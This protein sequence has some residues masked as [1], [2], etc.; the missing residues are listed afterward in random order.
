VLKILIYLPTILILAAFF[1]HPVYG[2]QNG[3]LE[4]S[5]AFSE[6]VLENPNEEKKLEISFT[7]HS[8]R[9]TNLEIFPIDFKQTGL[10]GDLNFVQ[11]PG[12]YSYSLSSFLSLESNFLELKGGEERI[13]NVSIKNRE[14][15]SPG[16]H[17]AAVVAKVVD[18]KEDPA[19]AAIAPSISSLILLRKSGGERFSLS[20]VS[21]DYPS[22]TIALAYPKVLTLLFQNEGNIHLIPYG[23]VEIKDMFN[24]LLHEGTINSASHIILPESKRYIKADLIKLRKSFPISINT[25][26]VHGQDSLKKAN[27]TFRETYLY[28]HPAVIVVF[29]LIPILTIIII[30]YNKKMSKK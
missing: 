10:F 18:I 12:S 5:P 27:Y 26:T 3:S 25:I 22:Q 24:R 15:I 11:Q 29:L 2:A 1:A 23:R 14:D 13:F 6:I 30:K 21:V 19:S 4:V 9:T 17:Y 7:N 8:D 20:L 28:I 16:G